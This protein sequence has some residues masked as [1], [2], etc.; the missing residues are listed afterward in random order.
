[1][2]AAEAR[3]FLPEMVRG[4]TRGS[5]DPIAPPV[6]L[7]LEA[8]LG[9]DPF[10]VDSRRN[11]AFGLAGDGFVKASRSRLEDTVPVLPVTNDSG[12]TGPGGAAMGARIGVC[13]LLVRLVGDNLPLVVAAGAR[14][15]T[16]FLSPVIKS[17]ANPSSGCIRRL[18]SHRR[19]RAMKSTNTSSSHFNACCSVFEL[20]LLLLPFVDTVTLGFPT[21]SKKSFFLVLCSMRCFSGGP[22]TSM[23]QESCSCSFSP[24]KIG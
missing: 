3:S 10:M 2:A 18:G 12:S 24:G 5:A 20:G 8:K 4:V 16:V 14:A 23:M 17:C 11:A 1:M 9:C 22:N 15:R 19:Q 6:E 7:L 21:E 13:P